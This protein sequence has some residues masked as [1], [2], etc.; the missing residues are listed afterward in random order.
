MVTIWNACGDGCHPWGIHTKEVLGILVK[1][2]WQWAKLTWQWAKLTCC[3]HG[4]GLDVWDALLRVGFLWRLSEIDW[5]LELAEIGWRIWELFASIRETAGRQ[6]RPFT[7][8]AG[9][10]LRLGFNGV[11]EAGRSFIVHPVAKR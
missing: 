2:T 10:R 7:R 6:K 3:V 9:R 8:L 5:S 11:K 4:F 1:L